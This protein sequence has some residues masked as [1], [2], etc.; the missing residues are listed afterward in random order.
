[1]SP[2]R[3]TGPWAPTVPISSVRDLGRAIGSRRQSLKLTQRKL[4]EM[5]DVAPSAISRL[6]REDDESIPFGVVIRLISSLE[7]DLELRPRGSRYVS[8]PPTRL[9]ELG[10]SPNTMSVLAMERLEE[11]HELGTANSM[12]ARAGFSDGTALYEIV[13]ALSRFGLSLPGGRTG[14]VPSPRD[15]DIFRRRIIDGLLLPELARLYGVNVERIRQILRF[16]G[17]SVAP[18][19]ASLRRKEQARQ[20]AREQRTR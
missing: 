3:P 19:A 4:G 5:T 9:N 12:L 10:L 11:I 17:L 15:L 8:R 18:S 2:T 7:L 20:R 16:F 6:E 13:C 1:M 14:R